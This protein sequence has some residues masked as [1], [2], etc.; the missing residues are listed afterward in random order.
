MSELLIVDG[1]VTT[2]IE[3]ALAVDVVTESA[4]PTVIETAGAQGPSGPQGPAGPAGGEAYYTAATALGGQR[5]VCLQSDGLH[6]ADAATAG[7]VGLVAGITPG[8]VEAGALTSIVCFS[9]MT[10]PSWNWTP[11][12]PVFVGLNGVLTQTLPDTAV[13]S[14]VVGVATS[15][16][17]IFVRLREPLILGD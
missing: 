5:A 12:Q 16:T 4:A 10:E 1:D 17:S 7:H 3:T 6:Y 11:E 15:P 8:A 2:V 14:Q 9:E 13:F